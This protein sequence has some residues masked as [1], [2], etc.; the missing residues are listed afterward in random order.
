[1]TEDVSQRCLH[2][3]QAICSHSRILPSSY[4][5]PG[6][7]VIAGD[8]AVASTN[9]SNVWEGTHNGAKVCIKSPRVATRDR[10]EI[11]KVSGW[12]WHT[13]SY[14]LKYTC[15][16]T[17]ILQGGNHVEKIET[18]EYCSLHRR[19]AKSIAICVRMDAERRLD[20]V[21]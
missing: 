3:L 4:I 1:M 6:G 19:Y 20:R 8:C 14:L 7:L 11:E 9:L 12:Y 21:P 5:I 15:R 2:K 16:R 10:Q 17:G 18:S 13:V